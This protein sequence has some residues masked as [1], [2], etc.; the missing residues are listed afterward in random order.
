M[1][2]N[3]IYK[4]IAK[5]TGGD[6]YI[7][8]VGPVRTGKSTFIHKFLESAVIPNIEDDYDRTR[9]LDEMPQSASGKTIM[10]TEPKFIPDESVKITTDDGTELNVKMI[11]CVG[12][13]VEGA[14]GSEEDGSERMVLTPWSNEEIP[15]KSAAEIGTSKV[16]GE[17]STIGILV[18]TDGT[19]CDIPREN[20][21]HAE[22]RAAKELREI[23]KP[24]A[25]ILN[26]KEPEGEAAHALAV[27]LEEKYGVPV[28]LLNCI[29]INSDDIREILR[30]LLCEFPIKSLT[31][32]LPSWCSELPSTHPLYL[33]VMNKIDAFTDRTEK[34]GDI[35]KTLE[36]FEGIRQVSLSA[37]EGIG[38]FEIPLSEEEYYSV[39][40]EISGLDISDKK[41]LLSTVIRLAKTE[42]EYKKIEGALKDAN[43]KGYGIVMP[44]HDKVKLEEPKVTKQA[45]GWGVKVS[46]SAESIHMIKTGIRAELCPIVG[47]EEQ[48]EEVV[49][50][51]M[52]EL[53]DDPA[54]VWES[55]MFGKSLYDLVSDGMNAKLLNIPDESREKIGETL[56]RVVNEGANGLIC[57]LL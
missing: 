53:Q 6:I 48:T 30:M 40:S 2:E 20:Y 16:I 51:L 45:G 46:A 21:I 38:K 39:M 42:K 41:T 37:G 54:K 35:E 24:F 23:G 7:G 25:I 43:E 28:A 9:T 22:E 17:H 10:T 18:T 27:S 19:I 1:N 29:E 34:F 13:L 12:F 32:T 57:I 8:V 50:Y 36:E 49:K 33:S 15:F 14:L 47:T 4:D 5:R 3:S 31:F 11:D 44:S 55:N 26:S 56:E 52:S